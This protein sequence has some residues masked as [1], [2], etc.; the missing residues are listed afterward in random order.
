MLKKILS[1]AV[2]MALGILLA[3]GHKARTEARA[4]EE[5]TD[6]YVLLD[7]VPLT[8]EEQLT[9]QKACYRYNADYRL[10]F[11]LL[12]SETHFIWVRGDLHLKHNA[13]GYFQISTVNEDRMAE[14]YGLDIYDEFQNLEA[15]VVILSELLKMF[16]DGYAGFTQEEA[17]IMCYKCGCHRGKELMDVGFL[18][19]SIDGII[20][21]K[22][23]YDL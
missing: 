5:V 15:G 17:A 12:E 14:D 8:S 21:G 9:I 4:Y 1:I 2:L 6:Y 20:E 23:K 18:L 16:P 19:D 3:M 7:D 13:I 10:A 22:S 11:S